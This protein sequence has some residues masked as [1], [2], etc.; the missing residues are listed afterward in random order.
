MWATVAQGGAAVALVWSGTFRDLLDYTS[1]GLAAVW[2]TAGLPLSVTLAAVV[3]VSLVGFRRL[4]GP[5]NA[6]AVS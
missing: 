4:M 2:R 3:M 1:V 6:K 5:V